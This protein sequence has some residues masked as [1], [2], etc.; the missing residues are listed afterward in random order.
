MSRGFKLIGVRS[1]SKRVSLGVAD[2]LEDARAEAAF[3]V[4]DP[5]D[6]VQTVYLWDVRDEQF[7]GWVSRVRP[8]FKPIGRIRKDRLCEA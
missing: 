8:Q 1:D 3:F 5:R 4:E 2:T 7:R 6:D